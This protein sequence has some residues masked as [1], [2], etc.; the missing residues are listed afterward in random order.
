MFRHIAVHDPAAVMGKH[1]QNKYDR[2]VAVCIVKKSIETSSP[3]RSSRNALQFCGGGLVFLGIHQDTVRSEMSTPGFRS[4]PCTGGAPLGGDLSLLRSAAG[5]C[6]IEAR[7]ALLI[8]RQ[9]AVPVL[10]YNSLT[11]ILD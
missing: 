6:G 7:V 8:S 10:P 5:K 3:P 1:T 4:S 11:Q 9:R 2:N